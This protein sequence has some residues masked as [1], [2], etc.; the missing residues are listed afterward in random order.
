M[1]TITKLLYLLHNDGLPVSHLPLTLQVQTGFAVIPE[2]TD[3]NTDHVILE[4]KGQP[5]NTLDVAYIGNMIQ[6]LV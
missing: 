4:T 1:N 6:I 5:P 3:G 2:S